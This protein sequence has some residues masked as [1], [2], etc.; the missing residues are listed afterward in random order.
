MSIY[1]RGDTF[2]YDFVVDGK[3]HRGT[4]GIKN[5]D[6]NSR[7]TAEER[8]ITLRS[9]PVGVRFLAWENQCPSR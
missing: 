1:L 5:L 4:T 6:K 9:Q 3:R 8:E 2:H 7:K